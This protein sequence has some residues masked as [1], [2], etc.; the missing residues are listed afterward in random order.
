MNG[1]AMVGAAKRELV[2]DAIEELGYRPNRPASNFRR[3]QAGMIGVVVS[4]IEKPHFTQMVRAVEDAAYLRGHRR[5]RSGA[6]KALSRNS[7]RTRRSIW[8]RCSTTRA[9][10]TWPCWR[11]QFSALIVQNPYKIGYEGVAEVVDLLQHKTI[12][13][14]L[15]T[16]AIVA[17]KANMNQPAIHK[18]LVPPAIG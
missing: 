1:S 7:R 18:L 2:V 5:P 8:W 9:T 17:T 13:H 4:D 11:G 14:S 6:S 3:R 16:G 12:P 10:S 15:D